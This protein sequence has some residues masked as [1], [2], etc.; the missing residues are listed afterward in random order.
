[1]SIYE[2]KNVTKT[3]LM[4]TQNYNIFQTFQKFSRF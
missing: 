1:M 3:L 4:I 2:K